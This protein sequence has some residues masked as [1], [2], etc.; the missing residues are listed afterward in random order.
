MVGSVTVRGEPGRAVRVL[1]PS[2][3][4]LHSLGGGRIEIEGITSDLG[5]MPRLD[6]AGSLQF[7]FGGRLRVTGDSEG[8][9]R[10]DVPIIVEYP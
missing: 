1:F 2:R 7:R 5:A 10:G 8:E 4:E 9:Y 3:I 6:S